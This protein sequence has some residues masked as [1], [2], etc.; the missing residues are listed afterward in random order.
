MHQV[1]FPEHHLQELDDAACLAWLRGS[2]GFAFPHLAPQML[3]PQRGLQ[4]HPREPLG[5]KTQHM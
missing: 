4:V 3:Q 2:A 5:Y 1:A